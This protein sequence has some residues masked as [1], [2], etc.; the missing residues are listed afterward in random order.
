MNKIVGLVVFVVVLGAAMFAFAPRPLPVFPA[1]AVSASRLLLLGVAA[2]DKRVVAVGERGVIVLSDDEGKS[3]RVAQT[4]TEATLT[5]VR[6]VDGRRGF[7][8]G[9][10]AV[11]LMSEDA[12]ETWKQV[13][14]APDA[15]KPLL[16]V[17][18]ENAE[19]GIAVGTYSSLYETVDGGKTWKPGPAPEGDQHFNA[20]AGGAG[21]KLLLVGE[22]GLL[23]RS[24]DAGRSWKRLESPY[25]GSFFGALALGPGEWVVYGLRG[26]AFRTSDDGASWTPVH[27]GGAQATLMGD[28]RLADGGILLVGREGM[29]LESRGE[30][31]AFTARKS[32][33]GKS[34]A[35][36]LLLP[37]GARVLVG[38]GGATRLDAGR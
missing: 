1:T 15:Q 21:G 14:A 4:P 37:S 19:R 31:G 35:G 27:P 25:K 12:G 17:W 11:I 20:L 3:W 26:N 36:A 22:A 28:A 24:D 6:F 33:D 5:A 38:E 9:H 34:L 13:H 18:F 23:L 8:V 29:L 2:A 7:A 32:P 10:D 30:A 16:A